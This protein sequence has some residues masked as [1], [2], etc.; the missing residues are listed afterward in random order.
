MKFTSL[1][2]FLFASIVFAKNK[3]L[4]TVDTVPLDEKEPK[5]E[6]R[7]LTDFKIPTSRLIDTGRFSYASSNDFIAYVKENVKESPLY[8]ITNF[9]T[10]SKVLIAEKVSEFR[11][12]NNVLFY[13]QNEKEG[14]K[15]VSVLYAISDFKTLIKHKVQHGLNSFRVDVN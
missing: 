10:L 6:L 3:V 5:V 15:I 4:Y 13:V 11:I 12:E 2:V 1:V 7:V 8:I 9:Q 14:D